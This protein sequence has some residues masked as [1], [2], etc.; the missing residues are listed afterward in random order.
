[1]GWC[2]NKAVQLARRW[3]ATSKPGREKHST[4][5]DEPSMEM[6]NGQE[7]ESLDNPCLRTYLV[8]EVNGTYPYGRKYKYH[9][10][11]TLKLKRSLFLRS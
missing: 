3:Q 8:R 9:F 2:S 1:M 6:A 7:N 4:T 11:F 5:E 10:V